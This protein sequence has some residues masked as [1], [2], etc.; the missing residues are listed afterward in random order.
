[1]YIQEIFAKHLNAAKEIVK[2]IIPKD[3]M[4]VDK[5]KKGFKFSDEEIKEFRESIIRFITLI[6]ICYA[7][8][9]TSILFF[10]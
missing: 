6:C 4:D 5:L 1:M 8:T 7:Y 3:D 9:Y 10:F 2:P